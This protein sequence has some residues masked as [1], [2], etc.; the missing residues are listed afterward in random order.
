MVRKEIDFVKMLLITHLPYS[1]SKKSLYYW[2]FTNSNFIQTHLYT[3]Q[4]LIVCLLTSH[5]NWNWFFFTLISLFCQLMNYSSMSQILFLFWLFFLLLSLKKG[6]C[7][8]KF[9]INCSLCVG[10]KSSQMSLANKNFWELEELLLGEL[11]WLF[12]V[13]W[14]FLREQ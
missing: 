1:R 3:I 11:D 13:I 10:H 6:W 14:Y 4:A 2:I 7:N 9:I 8:Y 5:W 12:Y